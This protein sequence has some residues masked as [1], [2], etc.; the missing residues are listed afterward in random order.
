MVQ[1]MLKGVLFDLDGTL[2]DSAPDFIVSLNNLLQKYNQPKLDPKIIRN[3]VSD[4]SWKLVSL[5]FGIEESHDD[6]AQLREEL[7]IE[8]EKNS[9]EY[10]G[11][12]A[13][14]S[15]T[16]DFLLELKIPYG[17]VTNKPLR[18]AEPI[19]TNEPTFKNCRTLVCPDHISKIKPDPEGIL[20]GCENLG[21]SPSD[22]IY[23]GDHI[24]DLE[25]GISAGTKVIACYFGY[26]LKLGDH[27]KS[28][29][30][31]NNPVDLIKLIKT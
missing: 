30:G 16:L 2:L 11:A 4:G 12:F 10:G 1:R 25:A 23:I 24:K 31:A 21:I 14:I 18:F 5:G 19:L 17:V 13:G 26:S 28:I 7:L 9:L 3:H 8:Y 15:D 6:C 20:K 22:C 27:S 29:Q